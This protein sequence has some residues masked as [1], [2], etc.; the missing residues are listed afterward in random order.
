M[1]RPFPL[2]IGK[3]VAVML[4][5]KHFVELARR[6]S[7]LPFESVRERNIALDSLC[8]ILVQMNPRFNR[9]KFIKAATS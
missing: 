4:T 7:A 8:V 1:T 2:T 9:D 6:F 3:G 5:R